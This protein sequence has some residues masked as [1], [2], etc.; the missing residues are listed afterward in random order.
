MVAT[1]RERILKIYRHEKIDQVVWQPRIMFWIHGNHVSIPKSRHDPS[2]QLYDPTIPENLFGMDPLEIHEALHTSIRYSAETLGVN[3]FSTHPKKDAKIKTRILAGKNGEAVVVTDTPVGSVRQASKGGYPV[4]HAVK[5][6]EDME[7]IKYEL[8][9]S[10]FEFNEPGFNLA[11][12]VLG[13]IGIAQSYYNR[14]PYMRCILNYIGFENTVIL[15]KRHRKATEDFMKFFAEWDDKMYDVIVNSPVKILNFGENIDANLAPPRNFKEYCIPY[16]NRRIKQLHDAGK[17]CHVHMDGSLKDLLPLI[18]ETDFDGVEA[19]TPEPQGDVTVDE[20]K[21]GLGD[22]VLL[23][24]IPATLFMKEFPES[25]LEETVTRLIELFG[26][27]LI[28]GVSDELPPNGQ[29]GRF[30]TVSKVIEHNPPV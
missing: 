4:E 25:R 30:A 19:A 5:T 9:Q 8:S 17:F 1:F 7:V 21:A 29:I 14:S 13:D 28:L 10:V 23:D 24:G 20:I 15:L 22:K 3:I 11:E 16:Y 26:H 18:K 6:P 2:W 12:E 27:R